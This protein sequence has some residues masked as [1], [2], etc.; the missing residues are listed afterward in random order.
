VFRIVKHYSNKSWL[1]S[2]YGYQAQY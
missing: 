2:A 1:S